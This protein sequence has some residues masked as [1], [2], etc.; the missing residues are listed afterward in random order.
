MAARKLAHRRQDFRRRAER[1]VHLYGRG[2]R[3][4][5][6]YL[7]R[8]RDH[9]ADGYGALAPRYSDRHRY[10]LPALRPEPEGFHLRARVAADGEPA[11]DLPLRLRLHLG[12]E[13]L[14]RPQGP[15]FS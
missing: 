8:K 2:E 13:R 14:E 1:E 15:D 11:L 6:L 4:L 9:A 12:R 3:P 7:W 10:L 5:P